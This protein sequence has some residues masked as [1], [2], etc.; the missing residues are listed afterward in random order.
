MQT[1]F[2]IKTSKRVTGGK[3]AA[4]RLR[5]S[6]KLPA[7]VYGPH[8]EAIT[9]AVDPKDVHQ[10]LRAE[11]GRNTVVTLDV[12]GKTQLAMLK[13]FEHHPMTRE[14]EHAD[15][16]MVA[17]DR[18]VI[19]EVPFTTTGKPKGVAEGGILRQVY[20]KLPVKCAPDKIPAKIEIDATEVGL[21]E[22]LHT[23]DLKLPEGVVVM[24]DPSQTIVSVVAP[25]KE[26]KAAVAE[27]AP[28]AGAPAA[29]PAAGA[30]AA[31]APA[32]DAKAAAPAKDAK[33]K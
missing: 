13:T 30:K 5:A 20:R 22:G 2:T 16:Y 8:A 9:I 14:L 21:G 31:A 3:G 6:G 33:K 15:F 28:A 4:R 11:L 23:R 17:L 24:L 10:I 29:A 25:E 18:P 32:K 12:E 19:V 27:G 26:E 7:I 1:Q